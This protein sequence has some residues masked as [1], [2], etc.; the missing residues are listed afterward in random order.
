[1]KL[2]AFTCL[3]R[4]H[5]LIHNRTFIW[6][7][8]FLFCLWSV[9]S[10]ASQEH[11]NRCWSIC[12]D[13]FMELSVVPKASERESREPL[14]GSQPHDIRGEMKTSALQPFC[15]DGTVE[16]EDTDTAWISL[17]SPDGWVFGSWTFGHISESDCLTRFRN[18]AGVPQQKWASVYMHTN[19]IRLLK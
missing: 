11:S 18:Q 1:M 15:L 7:S 19:A 12:S 17:G 9:R 16:H 13:T 4:I 6:S 14:H 3:D 2:T 5:W 8:W 10:S